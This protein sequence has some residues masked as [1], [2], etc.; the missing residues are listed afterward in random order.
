MN[1][2]GIIALLEQHVEKFVLGLCALFVGYTAW[3]YLFGTPHTVD[4][5]GAKVAPRELGDRVLAEAR[6][7]DQRMRSAEPPAMP[8]ERPSERLRKEFAAGLFAPVED[9]VPLARELRPATTFGRRIEVPGLSETE[10][11]AGSIQLVT[12]LKPTQPVVTTGRSLATRTARRSEGPGAPPRLPEDDKPVEMVWASVAVYFDRQAQQN[13]LVRAGY[14]THRQRVYLVGVD[15]ERQ[16]RLAG[17][18]WSEWTPVKPAATSQEITIPTPLFDD[19]T[20]SLINKSEIEAAYSEI[21]ARQ[22]DLMQPPFFDVKGGDFWEIPPLAGYEPEVEDETKTAQQPP[23]LPE[24]PAIAGG[25]GRGALAGGGGGGGGAVLG[26]GGGRGGGGGGAVLGGG[27]GRGVRSAP[28]RQPTAP[29]GASRADLLRQVREDLSLAAQALNRG[30]Y[31]R[32]IEIAASIEATTDVS[33]SFKN[34]AERIRKRAE[35]LRDRRMSGGQLDEVVLHPESRMPAMWAHDDTAESGKTYRYRARVTMWNRYV[36]LQRPLKNPEDAAKAV[37]A[38]EWSLPSEPITIR[39]SSYFFVR[40]PRIGSDAA[41]VEVW[42]WREGSWIQ[43]AFDVEVGDQI[44]GI[45]NVRTGDIDERGDE[46][47]ADVDFSTG[48]IVLDIR[49]DEVVP[50]RIAGRDGAFTYQDKTSLVVVYLDPADGQ[51]KQRVQLLDR[52]DPIRKELQD[53]EL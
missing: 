42:R 51:V 35:Q 31:G 38:G 19:T 30:E 7:L 23:R 37:I 41:S 32:A 21:R 46:V 24:P 27:G 39:P 12:P 49:A 40:G 22:H 53:Q 47:R 34:R 4:F 6:A 5:Q 17:G 3:V 43:Q 44:G 16:E 10:E 8:S 9:R 20:G 1:V 45:R 15:L 28:P 36:G 2:K 48:A 18:E 33:R 26:G 14:A 52:Y 29:T 25:G 50:D 11:A 13:E